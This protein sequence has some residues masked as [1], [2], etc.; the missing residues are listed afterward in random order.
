MRTCDD[1]DA[2]DLTFWRAAFGGAFYYGSYEISKQK[3]LKNG[4]KQQLNVLETMGCG[5]IA[6]IA[7][8][9]GI[10]PID[11]CKS[12]LQAAGQGSNRKVF[13]NL[14][15][16]AKNNGLIQTFYSGVGVTVARAALV[17]AVSFVV[18][19]KTL[20]CFE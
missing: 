1:G 5:I 16:D 3:L 19:E 2:L 17:T 6:G 8:W 14:I 9:G 18:Y 4:E 11:V 10:Y 7:F 20:L 15:L 13:E 12:R